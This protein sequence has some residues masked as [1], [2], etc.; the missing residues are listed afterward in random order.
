MP[1]EPHRLVDAM[2]LALARLD[3]LH[4]GSIKIEREFKMLF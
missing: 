4:V 1:K 3:Y 2:I